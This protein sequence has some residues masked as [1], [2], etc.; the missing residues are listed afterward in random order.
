VPIDKTGKHGQAPAVEFTMKI[1]GN[2]P[3]QDTQAADAARRAGNE[4][5]LRQGGRVSPAGAGDRVELS[6]DAAL[7]VAALNAALDAP[8]IRPDAVQRAREKVERGEIGTDSTR[9]ADAILDD[10]LP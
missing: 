1:D 5:A 3:A 2:R 8:S 4:A 10:L 7:R 9:L 6:G